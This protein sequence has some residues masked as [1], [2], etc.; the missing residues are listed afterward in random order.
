MIKTLKELSILVYA[1]C[2]M[3][4]TC[5]SPLIGSP[6]PDDRPQNTVGVILPL[7]G[8]WESIGQKI[9]KGIVMAAGVFSEGATPNVEYLIRDYGNNEESIPKIIEELDKEYRVVAIIGP[10]GE[11][12]GEIACRE[13]QSRNLPSIIFT[14]AETPPR[15]GTF[16]FR[17]FVTIDIQ[18]KTLLKAAHAIGITRFAIMYPDDLFGRTFSKAFQ[19]M[20][21]PFGIEI[22]RII[23]Y[24]Q[25]N[26]D[27]N[28]QVKSLLKTAKKSSP[29]QNPSG[30]VADFEALLIPDSATNAAM[31]ASY[32]RN[33]GMPNIRLFGP[34]LWDSPDFVKVGDK[35]VENAIFLS[36]FFQG[37]LLSSVQKFN[38]SFTEAFKYTP[39]VWEASAYDTASILQDFLLSQKFS[40]PTL[41]EGIA[42]LKDYHGISGTTS[43][44][45]DGSMEKT[46]YL[47]TVNSGKVSEFHP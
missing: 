39:S 6:P 4:F 31:I 38:R 46:V 26:I 40:R 13:S 1:S 10:V 44:F 29:A 37:S 18:A 20:A 47:L 16:C 8:K 3:L 14:Q 25:Q 5:A 11:R 28:Q 33:L 27:F 45:S 30:K 42:T 19:R 35:Y 9:L 7:T 15:E 23:V 41:R 36:G 2:L 21:P 32:I 22:V 17:N 34:T 12:A 24:P 43:F